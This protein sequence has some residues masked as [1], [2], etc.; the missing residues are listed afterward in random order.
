M[1][2]T[3][4]LT[5]KEPEML[6]LVGKALSSPV[7]LRI[8]NILHNKTCSVLELAEMLDIPA[9]SAGLHIK[10]LDEADLIIT[11]IQP[12]YRGIVKICSKKYE[13]LDILLQGDNSKYNSMVYTDMPI[14]NF[15]DCVAKPTCGLADESSIIGEEDQMSSF[16][17]PEKN[18]AQLIW[19]SE[20]RISYK[21]P[22]QLPKNA[23]PKKL[24]LSAELCSEVANYRSDWKSEIT[25]WIN[26]VECGTFLSLG[27]YGDRRGSLNP[28]WWPDGNSQYGT[29]A[30]WAINEKGSVV[31]NEPAADTN[32]SDLNIT[33]SHYIKVCL[34]IKDD[35]KYKGGINIFGEKFG[36]YKQNMV[37]RLIY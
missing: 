33:G 21:F 13:K 15:V 28:D 35:A 12:G 7:R 4:Y 26:D 31:N 16:Y 11:E 29:L 37:L 8:L 18:K 17:L 9:S 22:N 23:M 19:L 34:G 36:D 30:T 2:G 10:V 20:G 6:A 3:Q 1:P 5:T 24:E 25:L 27:D 32:I 14:G